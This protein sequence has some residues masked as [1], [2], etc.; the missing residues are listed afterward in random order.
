MISDVALGSRVAR[1]SRLSRWGAALSALGLCAALA[2]CASSPPAR[3]VKSAEIGHLDPPISMDQPLVIEFEAGDVIPLTFL[4]AGPFVESPKDA[5]PIPLRVTRHFFLRIDKSGLKSSVDGKS[6]D[7]KPVAP[8]QFQIGI[9]ITKGEGP[10]ATL[11]IR[12]P[13]P[14]GLPPN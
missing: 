4:L 6:F 5:P 7:A 9:G 14:P 10:K 2:G 8:G 1:G 12:T 13:T 11:S 3:Y